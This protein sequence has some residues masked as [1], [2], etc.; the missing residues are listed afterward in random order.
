MLREFTYPDITVVTDRDTI[1]SFLSARAQ[2]NPDEPLAAYL[3]G[4]NR[5][6]E[7]VTAAQMLDAVQKTARGLIA[8]GV[9][10]ADTVLIYAPTSYQWGVVDFACA[11]VGAVSVPVYDTD[12]SGQVENIVSET[13]PAIAFTAGEERA[14]ILERLRANSA[15]S[16]QYV[17]NLETD[18]LDA[19]EDWGTGVSQDR[20][21]EAVNAVTG[22]D[23]ATIVY[24]S[25]STG[26]PKG[27]MLSN[28]NFA[29]IVV[30][31]PN[32][33]PHML[34]GDPTRLLLF[35]PLAHCFARYIQYSTIFSDR[36]VVAYL[37]DV[38]HLLSDMRTFKP[39]YLLGVPRVFEKVYNAASQKAGAGVKGR[40]FAN[41]V[42]HFTQWSRDEEA[43][44]KHT[45]HE[46]SRH[47]FYER[48]V[49]DSIRS[50]MGGKL[51]F[52][53]CGGAPVNIDLAH[54][55]HG[56]DGITFIQGYG[57]TETAAPCVI[58]SEIHNR[59][60]SAGMVAPGFSC[61]LADDD[62]LEIKGPSVFVGYLND[63]ERTDE[64]FDGT[65]HAWLRTGDLAEIDD[66]GFI[67]IVGRKK[68]VIITAGGK[69]VSPAPMEDIIKTCPIVSQAVVI[70]DGR[71]FISALV[72]LDPDMLE[73]WL[74][75]QGRNG[76]VTVETAG[77]DDAVRSYIQEY[78]DRANS[79]VSRAESVRKFIVIPND[80]SQDD[81]TLTPSMKV[82]RGEVMKKYQD[83]IDN[84]IYA[85]K[86]S[87][88]P[89]A[90]TA[91]IMEAADTVSEST[92]RSFKQVQ[93]KIDPIWNK[94]R[95]TLTETVPKY[96]KLTRDSAKDASASGTSAADGDSAEAS[97]SA[98]QD[99]SETGK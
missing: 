7:Y 41:A 84:D 68:D 65:G 64:A 24:T 85:P 22:S 77:S 15:N 27:A 35:L 11:A 53:A 56:I 52:L 57:M 95:D 30:N 81:K 82:V 61:R 28:T 55:F 76:Q 32:I 96:V 20:L 69:N 78:I 72:T 90:P 26:K 8:L 39:S 51:H 3:K 73:T 6:W 62:E 88:M 83:I 21:D 45:L 67:Y 37:S 93:E 44:K 87:S 1:Y 2:K 86:P 54:F 89:K 66:D 16:V 36:G 47:V 9:K 63:P 49:G 10:K 34:N 31:G 71:P 99:I 50:A 92:Q 94:A 42:K 40:I 98:P 58:N 91:R 25:G 80:F 38:K 23:I 43:G 97:G 60:G 14:Q 75:G 79:T 19:I 70:G 18:G 33:L 74:T 13:H 5:D 17:F 4:K 59:V 48:T 12:S 29:H 46:R